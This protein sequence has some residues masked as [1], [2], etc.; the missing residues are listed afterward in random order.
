AALNLGELS[1]DEAKPKHADDTACGGPGPLAG[2]DCNEDGRFTDA[3]YRDHPRFA[4]V[5]PRAPCFKQ[6][7]RL[8]PARDRVKGDVNR[9]CILDPGD[10]IL[11]F[12]DGVDDDAN[13]YKDDICGWDFFKND[14]D[15]YDDTRYGH[16]TGEAR[17]SAAEANNGDGQPG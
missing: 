3:D 16:G 13:G 5:V 14:N 12:S 2:Y 8:K 6:H 1:K 10:I 9:N 17:D 4:P 15:P 7:D 11:M